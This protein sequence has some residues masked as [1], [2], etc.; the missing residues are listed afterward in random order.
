MDNKIHLII[1]FYFL[2][3]HVDEAMSMVVRLELRERQ[4]NWFGEIDGGETKSREKHESWRGERER[5]RNVDNFFWFRD[6]FRM[7]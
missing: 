2:F 5:E 7:L 3:V 6:R 4:W 1:R